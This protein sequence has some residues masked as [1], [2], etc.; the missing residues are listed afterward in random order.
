MRDKTEV[1]VLLT[2]MAVM[3]VLWIA[4]FSGRL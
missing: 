2:W 1:L 3:G 4:A